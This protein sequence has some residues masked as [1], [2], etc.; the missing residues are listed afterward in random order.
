MTFMEEGPERL[1][2]I[3]PDQMTDTQ[4]AA[5]AEFATIRG[6]D[7]FGP[8][9]VMLRSP[10]LMLRSAAMGEYVRYRSALSQPL[11]ELAILITAQQWRQS[12]Q[13]A[14]HAPIAVAAGVRD[15]I[16]GAI[17][18]GQRPDRMSDDQACVYDFLVE[19]RQTQRVGDET[20]ARTVTRLGEQGLVDLLGIAG[21]Y[22]FLSMVMNTARTAVPQIE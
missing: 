20:Y 19:L 14:V 17:A 2:A 8:F 9:A 5:A 7:V 21:H 12:Y 13:W 18:D 1:P 10:E 11:S 22:T 16:V 15:D 4:R 3:S 6:T